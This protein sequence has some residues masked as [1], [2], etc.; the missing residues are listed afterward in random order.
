MKEFFNG[1][2][3]PKPKGPQCSIQLSVQKLM[4][5]EYFSISPRLPQ[6]L[7]SSTLTHSVLWWSEKSGDCLMI[8]YLGLVS[9]RKEWSK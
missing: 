1:K 3:K 2:S 5:Y 7:S 6:Q 8:R 9:R 4:R